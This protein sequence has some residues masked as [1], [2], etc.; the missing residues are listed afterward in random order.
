[1]KK[2]L[3]VLIIAAGFFSCSDETFETV[4][5]DVESKQE[6]QEIRLSKIESSSK[7][8]GQYIVVLK[9]GTLNTLINADGKS[10]FRIAKQDL[11][12]QIKA[13]FRGVGLGE[14]N[15]LNAYGFAL[16]GFTAKLSH[17]QLEKLKND[18]RVERIEQD[19]M[20][21]LG[22]PPGKG[23]NKPG[24]GGDGGGG[25]SSQE[26]PWG[27]TRVG[28]AQAVSG[29]KA[30][31]IDSGIDLN[32]PDLNV[33]TAMSETF[34][35]SGK[36][37]RSADDGNGHGTHVAGTVAAIDNNQGVIGV[38][39]GAPVVA[40]KVLDSR[41]SG[42][43][44]WTIAALDYVAANANPGDAVNMSLGPSSRY[45]D[46]AVDD[47]VRNVANL[48]IL[49][50]KAAGNE[51]DDC[52]YYSPARVNHPN[53]LTVSAINSSDVFASFS[54]YG[55]PV[56]YAA[57]GV[58]VKS[59]WKGGGYNTISGTSMASPHVCGLLL[60]GNVHGD[61]FAINDPDGNADPIASH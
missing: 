34:V 25:S 24:D 23:P 57:P 50:A 43:F 3:A 31:I 1:M 14:N 28:G 41:G 6:A 26:T 29:K 19:E 42:S 18:P 39:P 5:P 59:T 61:G 15:V 20:V 12:S 48:G 49:I 36:D 55:S 45:T 38:A 35:T 13:N 16:E 53:A 37:S 22:P 58:A 9:K 32:H 8:P 60:V 17:S 10:N 2:L 7:I 52:S 44:S 54:N 30:W 11:T 47:A 51:S 21:T 46:N 27:I 56:D 4:S 33:D 40:L